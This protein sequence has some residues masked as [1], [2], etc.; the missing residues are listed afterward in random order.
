MVDLVR[1]V[2]EGLPEGYFARAEKTLQISEIIPL[3]ATGHPKKTTVPDVTIYRSHHIPGVP[4]PTLTAT[5]PTRSIPIAP[6]LTE[7]DFLSGIVIYQAGEGGL[8]G[9]PVTQIEL[10]SPA[11][12]PGGGHFTRYASKRLETLQRW[13]MR[14]TRRTLTATRRLTGRASGRG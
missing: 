3:I 7:E 8:L 5:A 2:N 14:L 1:A 9:R 6:L 11:N 4:A 13:I 12:K 10:L